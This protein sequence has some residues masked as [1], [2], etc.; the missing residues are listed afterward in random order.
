MIEKVLKEIRPRFAKIWYVP[1]KDKLLEDPPD[2]PLGWYSVD[3]FSK[4][5]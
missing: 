4:I 3:L 2:E 1:S 5:Q